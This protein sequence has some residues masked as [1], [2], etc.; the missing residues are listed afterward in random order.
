MKVLADPLRRYPAA[1]E[2]LGR[3]SGSH[4]APE[5]IHNQVIHVGQ[6]PDPKIRTGPRKGES[7]LAEYPLFTF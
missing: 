2:S 6:E 4:G 7:Y 3:E 5:R 1:T